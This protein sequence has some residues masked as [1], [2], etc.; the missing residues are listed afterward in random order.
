MRRLT[1][2]KSA[3]AD[4]AAIVGFIDRRNPYAA[5]HVKHAILESARKLKQFPE[6]GRAAQRPNTRLLV[7]TGLPYIL[8]YRVEGDVVEIGSVLDARMDR[9]PDLS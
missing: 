5:E 4:I 3:K 6:I 8:A 7:V 9:A 1:W 2:S